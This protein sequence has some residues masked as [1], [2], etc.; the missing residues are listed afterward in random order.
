MRRRM[1]VFAVTGVRMLRSGEE[2]IRLEQADAEDERER[3]TALRGADDARVLLHASDALL[4]RVQP[5]RIDQVAFV[6][7]D[8]IPVAQLIARSLALEQVEAEAAGV[9]DRDDGI[10]ACQIAELRAQERQHHGQGIGKPGGFD[11]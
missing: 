1:I 6:E 9:R 4:E 7:Q 3:Q 5:P 10:D 11:H 8:D 2:P